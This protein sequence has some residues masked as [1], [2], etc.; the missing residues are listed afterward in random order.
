MFDTCALMDIRTSQAMDRSRI[1]HGDEQDREN[2]T[3]CV[4][5]LNSMLAATT[6][7]R[8]K[9]LVKQ[10]LSDRDGMIAFG[11][12]RER[13]GKTG[14]AKLS[15]VFQFQ[16]TSSISLED[17]WLRWLKLVRQV[18]ITSLGD[19][20]RERLTIAGLEKA[21]ERALEPHL[22][23]R[24]PQ[25]WTVLCVVSISTCERRWT[26]SVSP[27]QLKLVPWCQRVPAVAKLDTRKRGVDSAM[28]SAA[29]VA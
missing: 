7:G 16:W 26:R 14:V 6:S 27:R 2:R 11:R 10:G 17:K 13:F 22:R 24:A 15:D 23:L 5:A 12:I 25:N 9:E 8:A 21:R 28:P 29:I 4:K 3:A 20:A 1:L 18:N 19:D